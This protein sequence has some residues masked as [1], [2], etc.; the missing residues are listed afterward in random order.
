MIPTRRGRVG[1]RSV[2]G[3]PITQRVFLALKFA[4]LGLLFWKLRFHLITNEHEC[5]TPQFVCV[6]SPATP[7]QAKSCVN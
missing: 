6:D 1:G 4:G 7:K 3:D 5:I 2:I